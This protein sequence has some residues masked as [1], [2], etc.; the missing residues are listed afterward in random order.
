LH[1]TKTLIRGLAAIGAI[2]AMFFLAYAVFGAPAN[3]FLAGTPSS[4]HPRGA[5]SDQRGCCNEGQNTQNQQNQ[6]ARDRSVQQVGPVRRLTPE[7][8]RQRQSQVGL[9][10][11]GSYRAPNGNLASPQG[12][13]FR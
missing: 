2:T 12:R 10:S 1:E 6:L 9:Q 4:S 13:S 5:Y 8:Q 7:Q 11:N 3:A